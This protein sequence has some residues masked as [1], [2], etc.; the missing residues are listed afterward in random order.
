MVGLNSI[1]P[2]LWFNAYLDPENN[3]IDV[4]S[5]VDFESVE[6]FDITG[7]IVRNELSTNREVKL[8]T[9]DLI[10]GLYVLRVKNGIQS[11]SLKILIP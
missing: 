7:R 3:Q 8:N 9:A 5:K 11:K 6:L 2:D 10:K 1:N 4:K